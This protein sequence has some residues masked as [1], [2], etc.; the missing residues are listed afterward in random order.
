MSPGASSHHSRAIAS[1]VLAAVDAGADKDRGAI[2][3]VDDLPEKLL[4]FGTLLEE[5]GQ[6]LVFVRSGSEA[7]REVLK[8]EFAVILLDVNM[9]DMDG[10]ETAGLIRQY[11]RAAHTPIIFITAYA[12][13]MQ[14]HRGYELGAVDYILS[15]VVPQ[16]LRTKVQVFVDL[17]LMQ[18]RV[19]RQAEE[20]LALAAAEGAR[21][22]AEE[23]TRRSNF[24]SQVS[25]VL[26]GSLEAE[27]GMR[28]LLQLMVPELAPHAVL[29]LQADGDEAGPALQARLGEGG[30]AVVDALPDAAAAAPLRQCLAR[31][32][33]G[34]LVGEAVSAA[35]L[36]AGTVMP[37]VHGERVLGALYAAGRPD[38]G[39]L[40]ELSGRAAIAFE[41]ARL[42]RSL[43]TEINERRQAEQRLQE[44]NRRKDEF[45]AMLSHELR[46]P[47]APIRNAVE[48]I[49]RVGPSDPKLAWAADVTD[50]QVRQLSR[51]VEELLDVARISQGKIALQMESVDL[52][53]VIAHSVETARPV[54]DGR[55]HRLQLQ[56]PAHPVWLRGDFARLSQVIGNLLNNAAK[57]TPE[58]GVLQLALQT[59]DG[60]ALVSVRDNGVGIE[61]ELLPHVFELFEQGKRSLD[62]SQ[63]GL[64]VGLTLV[65]RLVE[66]HHGAI[67]ARSGGAGQ[68]AEFVVRLPCLREVRGPAPAESRAPEPP[69]NGCRVLVVDDNADA[70]ETVAM[71]LE[72]EGHSV[73]TAGDGLE[74]LGRAATFE[75][76]VVVLDIGLPGLDGYEVARRLRQS[77]AC[78]GALLVALTGYGQSS[79]REQA[80]EAGFDHH[81]VKPADPRQLA[82]LVADWRQARGAP[83]TDALQAGRS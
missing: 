2:L 80:D 51:L 13:E 1:D 63:G 12:D 75:P 68:G 57:Y 10:Y 38:A 46:N 58:E 65:Q 35:G 15:P 52:Q 9:P 19:R 33:R 43:R 26:G 6:E 47:L 36:A 78:A 56:L 50:R 27:V 17:H 74:A 16:V 82:R 14:T 64:G 7:L 81:L 70:A 73:E 23:N 21:R 53:A 40:Q 62:R 25:R 76:D 29:Q 45:L 22:V 55:R 42:Y 20:R 83:G 8:R 61:P 49:R 79:D 77:S 5:L 66:L 41:N 67:E 32:L 24:L 28:A 39:L 11:K 34:E 72:L 37:L 18:R 44:S 60:H 31:A 4:V 54:I 3:I 69:K 30:V 59:Q 71:F 48:V